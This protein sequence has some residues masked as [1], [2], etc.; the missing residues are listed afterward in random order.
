MR[1]ARRTAAGGPRPVAADV[2]GA[3]GTRRPVPSRER[4]GFGAAGLRPG[5]RALAAGPGLRGRGGTGARGDGCRLPGSAGSAQPAGCAED[6]ADR[7][8]RRSA[9]AR[10]FP[11][12]SRGGRGATAPEHRTGLRR[13]RSGRPAVLHDGVRRRGQPR[14][15]AGRH[16]PV[17][18]GPCGARSDPGRRGRS[19][20]PERDRAPGS[21]AG[22]RAPYGRRGAQGER[23][24]SGPAAGRRR[25]AD[26]HRNRRRNAE[27]HGSR[28]GTRSGRCG[29]PGGGRLLARGDPVRAT[30]RPAAVPGG[31]GGGD[32]PP[33]PHP[34]PG[35]PVAA[36]RPGAP[37]PRH[38]LP[39][40]PPQGTAAPLRQRRRPGGRPQPLSPRRGGR[41]AT[42]GTAGA[43]GPTGSS[44]AGPVGGDRGR[45]PLHRRPDRL[46][47]VDSFRPC[48]RSTGRGGRP[49]G[50]RASGGRRPPG[51]G[52]VAAEVVL[53]RG[54][55]GTRAGEGPAGRPR[56]GR[57]RPR[58]R[59]G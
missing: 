47:G 46:G 52:P 24:R 13:R 17:R 2:P 31:D 57:V 33:T 39:E 1:V 34:G 49:G 22:E 16:A 50:H 58:R 51:H 18:A 44:A 3:G 6:G 8:A 32:G 27:L 25:R 14:P 5:D 35:T 28:A 43:D 53:V 48:G 37:R 59:A 40:V 42:G 21:E 30:H 15:K 19:R 55:G 23:L 12:G 29:G 56:V 36:E 45:R 54:A 4:V 7:R 38:R 9:R 10:A 41:G 11:A 20:P 26:R